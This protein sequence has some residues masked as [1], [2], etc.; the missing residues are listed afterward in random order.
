[1]TAADAHG[2]QG[3]SDAAGP[4]IDDDGNICFRPRLGRRGFVRVVIVVRRFAQWRN[5]CACYMWEDTQSMSNFA[6]NFEQ[7]VS[8]TP[9]NGTQPTSLRLMVSS[10][11]ID[12][13]AKPLYCVQ[14]GAESNNTSLSIEPMEWKGNTP[15]MAIDLAFS[16]L[17][18]HLRTK[19]NEGW[20]F[21]PTPT[22]LRSVGH[23]NNLPMA[24]FAPTIAGSTLLG[25]LAQGVLESP[26]PT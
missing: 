14:I 17:A 13:A 24:S 3:R 19:E 20:E 21:H 26:S 1:M 12:G 8:A 16:Y 15:L 4:A 22:E 9:P 18:L 10:T 6:I 23:E 5:V 2:W 7:T 25:K 11:V